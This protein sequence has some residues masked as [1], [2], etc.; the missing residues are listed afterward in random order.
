MNSSSS[1]TQ[2]AFRYREVSRVLGIT[3]ASNLLVSFG[4]IAVGI[5]VNSLSMVAD[6]VHS[7]LDAAANVV[8]LLS[9]SVASK[10]A[11]EDHPYGHQK[12][13]VVAALVIAILM[14]VACVEILERV[15]GRF[16]SGGAPPDPNLLSFVVMGVAMAISAWIS[17][18]EAKKSKAL[19]SSL[20]A[21]DSAHTGTD[22]LS[23][24]AVFAALAGAHFGFAWIDWVASLIVVVIVAR[25]ALHI[26]RQAMGVLS[27]Q[28][29]ID[30][31]RISEVVR[32]VP[33][34]LA[35]HKVRSHGMPG[36]IHVD[37]HIQVSPTMTISESHALTHRVIGVVKETLLGVQEVFV[38]TEPA[39]PED[40]R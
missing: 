23:C 13:E 6:G 37:L 36:H 15:L 34:I 7:L 26:I 31:N 16:F 28:V 30:P 40:Y 35:C 33:G 8:G 18:F 21:A 27:D 39:K 29:M 24:G 10:P 9:V 1:S 17:W 5:V 2:A 3:L 11:D 12:F 22:T 19:G 32:G 20:L 38:H 14:G 25:A 4:K